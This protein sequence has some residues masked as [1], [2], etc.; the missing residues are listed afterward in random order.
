MKSKGKQKRVHGK[1]KNNVWKIIQ[2]K[3]TKQ[4]NNKTLIAVTIS[5]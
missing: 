2:N 5:H 3:T 4:Q 1:G